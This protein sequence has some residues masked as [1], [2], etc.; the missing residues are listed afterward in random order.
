[1]VSI[2]TFE[3]LPA[4]HFSF[5]N[6]SESQGCICQIWNSLK[7][8]LKM[9]SKLKPNISEDATQQYKQNN[10]NDKRKVAKNINLHNTPTIFFQKLDGGVCPK[11]AK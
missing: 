11:V 9:I 3:V 7:L 2:M 6:S 8:L 4:R 5:F 10:D 1:M